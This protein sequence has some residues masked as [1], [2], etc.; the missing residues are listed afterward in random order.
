MWDR[1]E[2]VSERLESRMKDLRT[3]DAP[4]RR[5]VIGL[6]ALGRDAIEQGG[7]KGANLGELIAAGLPVPPGFC[8]TTAARCMMSALMIRPPRSGRR[9]GS[10]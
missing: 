5:T 6:E 7:G 10:P 8:V 3:P 1:W 9:H 4:P 2:M